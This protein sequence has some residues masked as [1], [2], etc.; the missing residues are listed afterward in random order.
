SSVGINC[1]SSCRPW[2]TRRE[3]I[4]SLSISSDRAVAPDP[5]AGTKILLR[6]FAGGDEGKAVDEINALRH[7]VGREPFP[8]IPDQ[9]L[10]RA[11]LVLPGYHDRL[12]RFAP[13]HIGNAD[14]RDH[15][16]AR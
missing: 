14:H 3:R 13:P 7:L 4:L 2:S 16:H 1:L 10:F 5:V 15:R 12:H 11:G 9:V 8:T 6:N